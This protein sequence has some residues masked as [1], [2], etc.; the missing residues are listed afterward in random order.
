[1]GIRVLY[2]GYWLHDGPPSGRNVV[3]SV[4]RAWAREFPDDELVVALPV[5][6]EVPLPAVDALP[7][8]RRHVP[9]PVAN[10]QLWVRTRL[11]SAEGGVDGVVS[12]NFQPGPARRGVP[13]AVFLHDVIFRDHP[14]WFTLAERLYFRGIASSIRSA[15]AILTSSEAERARIQRCFPQAAGRVW[16]VGL[17]LPEGIATAA[18][19]PVAR[20]SAR[21]FIL[22]VGRLNVRKNLDRLIA[23]YS[24]S[25]ALTAGFDLVI[26]G[27]ANGRATGHGH[28]SGG[29]GRVE[30]LGGVDDGRLK[31]LYQHAALFAF[32]SLDEGF[33]LPLL[34]AHSLGAPI[35]ASD[36][37]VF[38]ELGFAD[39]YFD[40][41]EVGSIRRCLEGMVATDARAGA[42]APD[43][44]S[45]YSWEAVAAGMREHLVGTA[46]GAGAAS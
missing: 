28:G 36:I 2:D 11:G 6:D 46:V 25:P 7:V 31:W 43:A 34:E 21:P 5:P 23:A 27:E 10:H 18:P 20:E 13:S 24:S 19:A 17:G 9:T 45:G 37:P 33:G 3:G 44:S 8:A 40:P 42:P 41:T 1:M 14:E 16:A 38:R 26:V 15:R 30:F 12:Q 39:A 29:P 22:A 4:L 32:P 35:A